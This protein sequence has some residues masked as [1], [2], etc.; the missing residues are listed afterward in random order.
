MKMKKRNA[1]SLILSIILF[2]TFTA[3]A[4]LPDLAREGDLEGIKKRLD[5]NT[6]VNERD[7]S[8]NSA[9]H[10][11][12][13]L[14]NLE[15]MKLLIARGADVNAGNFDRETPLFYAADA[16]AVDLL[17]DSG[18]DPGWLD[19]NKRNACFN[20]ASVNRVD[21]LQA[22]IDRGVDFDL[23]DSNSQSPLYIAA[24]H[25]CEEA[26]QLLVKAGAKLDRAADKN[27]FTPL[28]EAAY[29]GRVDTVK[30]LVEAGADLNHLDKA[31]RNIVAATRE[32]WSFGKE[33]VLA[34][35]EGELGLVAI[36]GEEDRRAAEGTEPGSTDGQETF[37]IQAGHN[38]DITTI[39]AGR[40]GTPAESLICTGSDDGTVKIW[41]RDALILRTIQA[42]DQTVRKA[43]FSPDGRGVFSA[44][45]I[46]GKL[47]LHDLEGKLI[48][49]YAAHQN[50]ITDF[51]FSPEKDRIV[52]VSRDQTVALWRMDG[53][54]IDQ[55]GLG[56]A[57]PLSVA[58]APGGDFFVVGLDT[59]EGLCIT[60]EMNLQTR[61]TGHTGSI[62]DI[63]FKPGEDI[64]AT[65]GGYGDNRIRIWD[66]RGTLLHTSRDFGT[67]VS[68][69]D[70]REDGTLLGA[71]LVT[72]GIVLLESNEY[73]EKT[74][75]IPPDPYGVSAIQAIDLS[76]DRD[77]FYAAGG[78]R[79]RSYSFGGEMLSQSSEGG[80]FIRDLVFSGDGERLYALTM[81]GRFQKW[82]KDGSLETGRT[83]KWAEGYQLALF[84]DGKRLIAAGLG[85]FSLI[86]TAGTTLFHNLD[87]HGSS[88]TGLA[89]LPDGDGFITCS[90]DKSIKWWTADGKLL[91]TV[92]GSNW[93]SALA[94]SKDGS[95][96]CSGN[97]AGQ[98]EVRNSTGSLLYSFQA[99]GENREIYGIGISPDNTVL[100]VCGEDFS[101]KLFTPGGVFLRELTGHTKYI[102]TAVF[103]PDGRL[104]ASG[105]YDGTLRLWNPSTGEALAVFTEAGP[106]FGTA[107]S[108]SGRFLASGLWDGTITRWNLEPSLS[109]DRKVGSLALDNEWITYSPEGYFD[110][111][112]GGGKLLAMVRGTQGYSI[113]QYAVK[114]N[115]PDILFSLMDPEDQQNRAVLQEAYKK[116]LR[117]MGVTEEELAGNLDAPS[118]LINTL[119][120]T[121]SSA[122]IQF[123]LV[124]GSRPVTGY[125]IYVNDVPLYKNREPKGKGSGS[126][127]SATPG[128]ITV[129]EEIPLSSGENKIE[130]SCFD[131]A[132]IESYRALRSL[133]AN[134]PVKPE[135][136]YLGFGVSSYARPELNLGYA[137]KD[138][139]D[140]QRLFSDM[141]ASFSKIHTRVYRDSQV[142]PETVPEAAAFLSEARV[143]DVVVLFI[144]GH[145]V[146]DTDP[147]GTYYYLA[148]PSDPRKLSETAIPFE[149]IEEILYATKARNKLFLMDTCESGELDSE[150]EAAN[151]SAAAESSLSPRTT[152]GLAIIT[153]EE[154]S[155]TGS[156]RSVLL[157]RDRYIF[158][159]LL[160]RSGTIVFSSSRGDEFSYESDAVENG[161]FTEQILSAISGKGD[162]DRD[163][164]LST[165]ELES[166]V[167]RTVA[168]L[169]GGLQHPTVD[170]DNIYAHFSF[171]LV[172]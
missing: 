19:D 111:S 105:S 172:R 38:K 116:R 122:R 137:A 23:P 73:R 117:R 93:Y 91:R 72:K 83:L 157:Q 59:G 118:V 76:Q 110:A 51:D 97:R 13:D 139:Q 3:C 2:S 167:S 74:F 168:E 60:P 37:V 18:A 100:A 89:V 47:L 31:G 61:C 119:D 161:Y 149:R 50:L 1:I 70:Y 104:F 6:D 133:T 42:H 112:A 80:G 67:N 25:G 132:G 163:G 135:L 85:D 82:R 130:V 98:V 28:L 57:T 32:S 7:K 84:P 148:H 107:F 171:P 141:N 20:P 159:D 29:F 131:S 35:L 88:I 41:N 58:W 65:A 21:A 14:G 54:L 150:I 24:S 120:S 48:R 11:A 101:V 17:F 9:L 4:T 49:E 134:H 166:Y 36:G 151:F 86:D 170:R 124:P 145:G 66:G 156:P 113:D 147:A 45:G 125:Q 143:D 123:T 78:E 153:R 109:E 90:G 136:Y 103:S 154:D 169:S 165:T 16:E 128:K 22:L 81:D 138:A 12:A 10:V 87:A 34:Y 27:G 30:I 160:R 152:R 40:T 52:T 62:L 164:R 158:N 56:D 39:D 126:S 15:L 33:E 146:H 94:T 108:P 129:T 121:G 55:R 43:A 92:S 96:V 106:I 102:N 79:L 155:R 99:L 63:A 127:G 142:T 26:V 162:A 5:K 68:D 77:S 46:H 115:R 71:S 95:M 69:L 140:L 114:L 144:A 53:T 64:F 8:A 44:G 75:I